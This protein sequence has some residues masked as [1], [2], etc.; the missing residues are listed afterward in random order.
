M[1]DATLDNLSVEKLLNNHRIVTRK[2]AV[3]KKAL[4]TGKIIMQV[5]KGKEYFYGHYTGS[6]KLIYL[7]TFD[8]IV[9]RKKG[10][11]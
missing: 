10:V 4:T 3:K 6:S 7:G 5:R 2:K 8:A 11:R 9:K 1:V